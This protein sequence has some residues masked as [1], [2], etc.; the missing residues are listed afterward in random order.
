MPFEAEIKAAADKHK[1][2]FALLYAQV[3]QESSFNPHAVSKSGA[4]GLLQL[5]PETGHE[6]G[7]KEDDF[8]DVVKNLDAGAG[9]LHKKYL[10]CYLFITTLPKTANNLCLEDDYWMLALASYNGGFGYVLKAL[11]L[12]LE[13]GLSIRWDNVDLML[14]NPRCECKG[15]RPDY[16]QIW[17]YVRKIFAAY[18][19][20]VQGGLK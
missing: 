20:N 4:R 19:Q 15:R 3:A 10:S 13:D 6:M 18:K 12:C 7:L 1:I 8:F 14:G 11:N 9:Y 2:P 16:H 17:A 5:M